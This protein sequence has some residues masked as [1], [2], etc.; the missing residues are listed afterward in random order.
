[1]LDNQWSHG[2][3]HNLR[4]LNQA[5]VANFC[6]FSF[7][8]FVKS[9]PFCSRI[10]GRLGERFLEALARRNDYWLAKECRW[11]WS[12]NFK[13]HPQHSQDLVSKSFFE[14][15]KPVEKVCAVERKNDGLLHSEEHL[16]TL[17]SESI[18]LFGAKMA[19]VLY[20]KFVGWSS[21]S[22][23]AWHLMC[24]FTHLFWV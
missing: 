20:T 22:R 4:Q 17:S 12:R 2:L 21:K 11:T 5:C 15:A 19:N 9:F 8:F 3:G 16:K 18:W 13:D 10:V 6:P 23:T 14:P 7:P 1:M 24:R